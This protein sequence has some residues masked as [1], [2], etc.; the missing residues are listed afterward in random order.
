[1]NKPDLQKLADVRGIKY[2]D[3]T[4]VEELEQKLMADATAPK[5]EA[6]ASSKPQPQRKGEQ[7]RVSNTPPA[8]T[9]AQASDFDVNKMYTEGELFSLGIVALVILSH[10]RGIHQNDFQGDPTIPRPWVEANLAWQKQHPQ[11]VAKKEAKASKPSDDSAEKKLLEHELKA[12]NESISAFQQ[13][14]EEFVKQL[15]EVRRKLK[16]AREQK[17]AVEQALQPYSRDAKK[18]PRD[19][20]DVVAQ[21]TVSGVSSFVKTLRSKET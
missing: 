13:Q 8:K 1:M 5:K 15:V 3:S 12:W 9:E 7:T 21:A 17:K 11:G 19:P 16:Y 14:E 18:G 6:Q 10:E 4:T 2:D 20:V